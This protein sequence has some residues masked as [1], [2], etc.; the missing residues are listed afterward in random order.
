MGLLECPNSVASVFAPG[1]GERSNAFDG[2][3]TDISTFVL[4]LGV[5]P[6]AHT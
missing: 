4:F 6:L 1:Q 2:L 5:S 3:P